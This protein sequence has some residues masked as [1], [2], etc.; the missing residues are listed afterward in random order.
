MRHSKGLKQWLNIQEQQ[1]KKAESQAMASARKLAE[2]EQ[3]LQAL[4]HFRNNNPLDCGTVRNGL[5]LNNAQMFNEQLDKVI[6][7]QNQQVAIQQSQQRRK[8]DQ[9]QQ[10]QL[11]KRKTEVLIERYQQKEQLAASRLEQKQIDEMARIMLNKTV[12]S[13]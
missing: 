2:E 12:F 13:P 1:R 9:L 3:R 7:H 5:T 10:A 6:L 11:N 8:A 4:N